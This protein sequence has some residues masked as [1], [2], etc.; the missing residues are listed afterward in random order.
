[1]VS[2]EPGPNWVPVPARWD[3]GYRAWM[4]MLATPT[5]QQ[6]IVG[7]EAAAQ[8]EVTSAA[9]VSHT[10]TLTSASCPALWGGSRS[11]T[12]AGSPFV[13]LQQFAQ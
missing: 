8:G 9:L 3:Q 2:Q 7:E 11:P 6:H 12:R 10:T 1:M 4:S 13:V 5:P